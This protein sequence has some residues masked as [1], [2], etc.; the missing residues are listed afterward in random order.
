MSKLYVLNGPDIGR[1]FELKEGVNYIGRFDERNDVQIK[2]RT[3]SRRHLRILQKGNSYFLTDLGSVNGTFFG[4]NYLIPGIEVEVKEGVPIAIAMTLLCIGEQ[5]LGQVMPFLDSTGL[6]RETGEGSGIFAIHKGKTN[7]KKLEALCKVSEVLAL[8]LPIRDRLGKVL[9]IIVELL[10]RIDRAAIIL[11]D[12]ITTKASEFIYRSKAGEV[13]PISVFSQDA[14]HQAIKGKRAVAISDARTEETELA[15]TLKSK[16]ITS[17]LCVP[18]M[19][20]SDVLGVIYLDSLKR[21]Y[22]FLQQDVAL[23]QDIARCAALAI[24]HDKLTSELENVADK[25]VKPS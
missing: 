8:D 18:I 23:F 4:G 20:P 16:E 25:L 21:P 3:V 6:T 5:S 15:A 22:G 11:I 24:E 9:A 2:D 17:V 7:Q 19:S 12:P 14:V 10:V 13:L 1:S